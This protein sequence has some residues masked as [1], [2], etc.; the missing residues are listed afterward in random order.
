MGGMCL[1]SMRVLLY[2]SGNIVTYFHSLGVE[3]IT[4]EIKGFIRNKK[5]ISNI[6]RIQ[7]YDSIKGEYS[8]IGFV[9]FVLKSQTLTDFINLFLP[10]NLKKNDKVILNYYLK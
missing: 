1:T 5:I 9:D 8:S 4:K 2:V 7:A 6:Y 10:H 3:H